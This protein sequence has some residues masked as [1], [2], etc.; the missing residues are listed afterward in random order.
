MVAGI[1]PA[2]LQYFIAFCDGYKDE[3]IIA[4]FFAFR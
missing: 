1:I 2:V 3:K 4:P